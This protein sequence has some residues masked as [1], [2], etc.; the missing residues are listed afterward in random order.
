[1][2]AFLEGKDPSPADLALLR[3]MASARDHEMFGA[4]LDGAVVGGGSLVHAAGVAHIAG[5]GVL[6]HARRRGIQGALIRHRLVRASALGCTVAAS[7]TLPGTASHR[8]MERH[9]FHA[10]YPKLVMLRELPAP[11][12]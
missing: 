3:P 2:S 9:G 1:M 10:A 4:W 8:N 5:T 7:S 11:P 12:P 6:P